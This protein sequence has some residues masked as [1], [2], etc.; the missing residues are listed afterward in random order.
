MEVF[1][2]FGGFGDSLVLRRSPDFVFALSFRYC[3]RVSGVRSM[4]GGG[5]AVQF[6]EILS[7]LMANATQGPPISSEHSLIVSKSL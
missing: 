6:S 4:L 3:V 7:W 2:R 1:G 5:G